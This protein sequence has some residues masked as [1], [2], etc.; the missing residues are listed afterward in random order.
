MVHKRGGKSASRY[1]K[2]IIIGGDGAAANALKV[3]GTGDQQYNNAFLQSN[4]TTPGWANSSNALRTLSGQVAG[5]SRSRGSRKRS[6][7]SSKRSTGRKRPKVGG[8][9]S[10]ILN[11]ALAPLSILGMQQMYGRKS[12]NSSK[13]AKKR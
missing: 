9:I 2:S 13:T 1:S 12:S 7:S 5:G 4:N 11:Q 10:Y 8:N 3:Y 6:R